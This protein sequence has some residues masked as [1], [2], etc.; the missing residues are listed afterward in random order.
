ML[1]SILFLSL[2]LTQGKYIPSFL[3][4]YLL[5][6]F[7]FFLSF[8]LRL[9][10]LLFHPSFILFS[11][12]SL[13]ILPFIQ[14][15][16]PSFLPSFLPCCKFFLDTS[17]FFSYRADPSSSSFVIKAFCLQSTFCLSLCLFLSFFILPHPSFLSHPYSLFD[18]ILPVLSHPLF[19][20]KTFT[21]F[22]IASLRFPN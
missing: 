15:F 13:L 14:P 17:M 2:L 7:L 4:L 11:C 8:F 1:M 9:F 12:S 19:F 22:S 16:L 5:F 10:L 18:R 6:S 3:S 21:F 20:F